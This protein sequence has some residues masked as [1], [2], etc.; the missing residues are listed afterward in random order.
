MS[1]RTQFEKRFHEEIIDM[2]VLTKTCEGAS[3]EKNML[4]PTVEFIASVNLTTG[5]FSSKKGIL[6]WLIKDSPDRTGW[7]FDF[8]LFEIYHIKAR[9]G[10]PNDDCFPLPKSLSY[11]NNCYMVVDIVEEFVSE[12]RLDKIREKVAKPVVIEEENFGTFVLDRQISLFCGKMEWMEKECM[13]FLEPDDENEDTAKR[14]FLF[15]QELYKDMENRDIQYRAYAAEEL[16]ELANEWLKDCEDGSRKAAPIT[17]REFADRIRL[18][19]LSISPDGEIS[20]F[21][22]DDSLFWGHSVIVEAEING[23]IL[24][25]DIIG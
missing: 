18:K 24:S 17:K 20:L 19:E 25:A 10:I 9:K 16:T 14:A 2:L 1:V 4:R 8:K 15:F 5:E 23:E 12:P 3:R 22:D 13:V 7:G 6:E 21:Y 11:M